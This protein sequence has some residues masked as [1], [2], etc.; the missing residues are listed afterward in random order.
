MS[1]DP[2]DDAIEAFREGRF[3]FVYDADG[4]EEETD[5]F[6]PA[7]AC[8]PEH[9]HQMRTEGGGLIF[10]MVGNGVA[11]KIGLPF[12][13]DILMEAAA[14]YDVLQAFV[15]DDIPYDTKSSFSVAINH[16]ETFTGITDND[17]ALTI[18]EFGK[19][20]SQAE[21]MAPEEAVALYG[22]AFRAPGHVPICVASEQPLRNR[23]G[24]TELSVALLLMAGMQPVAV[25]CEMM[26]ADGGSLSRE[27][28]RAYAEG[29]GAPFLEGK[30][31]IE[32]WREWSG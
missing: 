10:L 21:D 26:A 29:L 11:S 9:V 20:A 15:P 7:T 3:V 2:V 30:D 25:G 6:L 14:T 4:R 24:H 31:I 19:L 8:R 13:A 27:D 18:S 23:F 1:R 32:R 22:R 28:A 12:M 16:R 5:F 17:R